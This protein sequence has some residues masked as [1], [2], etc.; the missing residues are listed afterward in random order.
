MPFALP[1]R[2]LRCGLLTRTGDSVGMEAI[3]RRVAVDR[4]HHVN[5]RRIDSAQQQALGLD[6]RELSTQL[7]R[8]Y[9]ASHAT[10]TGLPPA[11]ITGSRMPLARNSGSLEGRAR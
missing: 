3:C 9:H 1:T 8:R 10:G 4:E 2:Q 6:G 7:I 11:L 5:I